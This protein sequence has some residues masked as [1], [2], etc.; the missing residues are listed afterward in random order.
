MTQ[1]RYCQPSAEV[2]FLCKSLPILR[3]QN[4]HSGQFAGWG[5]S[6]LGKWAVDC[7]ASA[8]APLPTA[9]LPSP[10]SK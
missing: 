9:L 8:P 1:L 2:K 4:R 5:G 6:P 7:D 10:K 3:D